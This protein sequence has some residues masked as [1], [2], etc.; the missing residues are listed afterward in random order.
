MQG[1]LLPADAEFLRIGSVKRMDKALLA[2]S[3]H[4]SESRSSNDALKELNDML[5]GCTDA[6]EQSIIQKE[7]EDLQKV[8]CCDL[9]MLLVF[10]HACGVA[11]MCSL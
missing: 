6:V 4:C 9:V 1:T 8:S 10:A 2:Y 3:L 5:S 7:I 11:R